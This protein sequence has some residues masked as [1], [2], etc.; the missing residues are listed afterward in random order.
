MPDSPHS[1]WRA[2]HAEGDADQKLPPR[3]IGTWIDFPPMGDRDVLV[4]DDAIEDDAVTTAAVDRQRDERVH[5]LDGVGVNRAVVGVDEFDTDGEFVHVVD[6]K[7][8]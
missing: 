1:R 7:E 5:L 8:F 2:L 6:A 3:E 4:P